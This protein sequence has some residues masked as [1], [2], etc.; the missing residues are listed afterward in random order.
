MTAMLITTNG[1]IIRERPVG[2]NDKYVEILTKDMGIIEVSVKG[3][4]KINSKNGSA[5]QLLTYSKICV[6]KSRDR[7]ILNSSQTLNTFYN[8]RLDMKKLAL[9]A[10]LSDLLR[11]TTPPEEGSENVLRL[12]LNT[13]YFL[14]KGNRDTEQLK[15]IFELRLM[16]KIGLMPQL[17]GCY[18]CYLPTDKTMYFD[19][20]EGKLICKNCFDRDS[21]GR[22]D[23][24]D[25][26]MLHTIRFICLS[27]FEKIFDFKISENC[28]KKLS[29]ICERYL[30]IQLNKAF[31]TLDFYKSI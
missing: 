16:C 24:I 17:I 8:I 23:I 2:E 15:I 18:N 21:L 20:Y 7:Y 12:F 13:L 22:C 1:I 14:D 26:T 27:E 25:E 28:Q 19:P 4:R 11:F 3:A 5:T 9:T 10:Y 29:P 31:Q 30:K 6:N